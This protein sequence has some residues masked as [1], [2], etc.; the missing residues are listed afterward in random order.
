M[1]EGATSDLPAA[2]LDRR[3]TQRQ[4]AEL[5][6]VDVRTVRRWVARGLLKQDTPT[7]TRL[8]RYRLSEVE[9]FLQGEA[10]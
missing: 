2:V 9:R 5:A 3:L 4:V 10:E 6:G 7:G 8:A 1:T